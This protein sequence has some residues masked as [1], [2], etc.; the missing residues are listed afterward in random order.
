MKRF[1]FT[2][3]MAG[4]GE[5]KDEA[6]RDA[7]EGFTLDNGETPETFTEEEAED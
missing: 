4:Y 6:W 1:E 5:D 7:C 2:I 3:T